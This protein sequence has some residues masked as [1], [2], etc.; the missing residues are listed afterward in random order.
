[1]K[2]DEQYK[3]YNCANQGCYGTMRFIVQIGNVVFLQCNNC[4][5]VDAADEEI[6]KEKYETPQEKKG[7][8]TSI[9]SPKGYF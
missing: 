3:D 5:K 9:E 2:S 8:N 1:M 6:I 4:K 7:F